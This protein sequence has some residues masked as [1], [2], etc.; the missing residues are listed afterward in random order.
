MAQLTVEISEKLLAKLR[1]TGRPVQEVI[2]ESLERT[3]GG[4]SS[5][6]DAP[7][8]LRDQEETGKEIEYIRAKDKKCLDKNLSRE[9]VVRR[10]LE[11]G[12]VRRPEEYDGPAVQEWLALSEEERQQHIKEMNEMYFPD[13]PASTYIIESRR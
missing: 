8:K 7:Y 10:L 9:E 3:L 6:E 2:T 5:Q 11:S 13:S 12:F 4:E 1:S